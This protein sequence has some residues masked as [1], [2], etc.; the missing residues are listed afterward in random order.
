MF[1]TP[2]LVPLCVAPFVAIFIGLLVYGSGSIIK[3]FIETKTGKPL[4][5]LRSV[6]L[7]A[8][9]I[10]VPISCVAS[11]LLKIGAGDPEPWFE[12][13]PDNIIGEWQL[14][15]STVDVIETW[16]YFPVQKHTLVFQD[17]GTFTMNNVPNIWRDLSSVMD[18][19]VKYVTG[20]G[21]WQLTRLYEQWAVVVEFQTVNDI[22]FQGSEAVF[23]FEKHLPPYQLVIRWFEGKENH[24]MFRFDK[25]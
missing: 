9:I 23:Y 11:A 25:Q 4:P 18:N 10:I 21:T 14:A 15:P 5:W 24:L 3:K 20:S 7:F 22:Q 13:T 12:P 19:D 6:T 16:E 8:T 1:D 17:D 2:D